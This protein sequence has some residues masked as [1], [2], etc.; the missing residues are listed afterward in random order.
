MNAGM[1]LLRPGITATRIPTARLTV[2]VLQIDGREGVPVVLVHGNV[3]S[4]LFWQ[5]L[6]LDLP[7]GYRPIA[8]DLRG[9]GDTDPEPVD[10]TRGVG[11][12]AAAG[13]SYREV[14]IADTGH[15]P[16]LEKPAEFMAAFRAHLD[17]AG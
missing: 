15:S 12:Y 13:G 16:F 5:G 8:I 7:A 3:S 17:A 4:A 10:A 6:M 1:D 14:A 9:F 11:D 2:N